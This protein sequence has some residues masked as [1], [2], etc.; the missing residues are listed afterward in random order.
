MHDG[1]LHPHAMRQ[2]VV[3]AWESRLSVTIGR[4]Q[5]LLLPGP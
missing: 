3:L 4:P 5:Q 2:A 1:G